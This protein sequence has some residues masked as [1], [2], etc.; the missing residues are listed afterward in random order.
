MGS[1]EWIVRAKGISKTC[2]EV[3]R[4]NPDDQGSLP[5]SQVVFSLLSKCHLYVIFMVLAL[6]SSCSPQTLPPSRFIETVP[7]S[8]SLPTLPPPRLTIAVDPRL[9]LLAVIQSLS[10]YDERTGLITNLDFPY[11]EKIAQRFDP[12]RKHTAVT[13]FAEMSQTAFSFDAPPHAMLFLSPPPDLE[14]QI[15][16]SD[17]VLERAGGQAKLEA[18][19]EAMRDF[20]DD[21]DF[22]QFYAENAGFYQDLVAKVEAIVHIED[23]VLLEEY[24]GLHQ[25][26]YNIQLVPLYH[27]G[28]LGRALKG[29]M[30]SSMC[31]VSTVHTHEMGNFSALDRPRNIAI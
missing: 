22:M 6:L 13:R 10:D 12:Y 19:I 15:P 26:S 28:A 3:C 17:Y 27:A 20:S 4:R 9:E 24:Y 11:K 29:K 1:A 7:A 16:F 23:L 18:F 8:S 25:H 30:V 21:S 31:T 2:C 5:C 14:E